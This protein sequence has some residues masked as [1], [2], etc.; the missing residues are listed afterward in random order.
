LKVAMLQ[1]AAALQWCDGEARDQGFVCLDDRLRYA[2]STE[3]FL[4]LPER[5]AAEIE[6][7]GSR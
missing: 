6:V 2:A 5:S 1:L 7:E 4:V 3:E